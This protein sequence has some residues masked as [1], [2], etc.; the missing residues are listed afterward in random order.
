MGMTQREG[1]REY[2]HRELDRLFP[3]LRHEYERA[4]GVRYEC[5][6]RNAGR[7]DGMCRGL[8]AEMGMDTT[9]P[10]YLEGAEEQLCLF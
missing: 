3:G 9:I 7:L 10:Q 8:C 5:P 6:A 2:F 1:Q 4:F